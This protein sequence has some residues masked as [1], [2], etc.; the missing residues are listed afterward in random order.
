[1]VGA[2]SLVTRKFT[3]N[4]VIIAGHPAKILKRGYRWDS[5]AYGKYKREEEF[6]DEV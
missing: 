2:C 4:N 3:E 5:R 6:S 1:M